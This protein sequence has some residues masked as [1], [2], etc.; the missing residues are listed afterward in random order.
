MRAS[1]L[2]LGM[3][4]LALPYVVRAAPVQR[5]VSAGGNGHCYEAFVTTGAISSTFALFEGVDVP[6]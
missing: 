1:V 5:P 2:A 6:L 3:S 4:G